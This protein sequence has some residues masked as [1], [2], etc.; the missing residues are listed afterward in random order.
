VVTAS[1]TIQL[2]QAATDSVNVGAKL[3]VNTVELA[4]ASG[5]IVSGVPLPGIVAGTG[6]GT[7]NTVGVTGTGLAGT[8][9]VLTAGTPTA[10]ATVVTVTFS[11]AYTTTAP[12][13]VIS[14]ANLAAALLTGTAIVYLSSASTT[15]FVLSVGSTALATTT[16]YLWNYVVIH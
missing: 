11:T 15:N 7:G 13:V 12:T 1:H 5:R 3:S 16:T 4:D 6:A 9:S 10:S 8:I 14:P 2:G